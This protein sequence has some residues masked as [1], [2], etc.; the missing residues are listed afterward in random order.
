MQIKTSFARSAATTSPRDT[1]CAKGLEHA[2]DLIYWS[3]PYWPG[4]YLVGSLKDEKRK[5]A[6]FL[7]PTATTSRWYMR[8]CFITHFLFSRAFFFSTGCYLFRV[9]YC[10][11][12]SCENRDNAD[13]Q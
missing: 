3:A 13:T 10:H 12:G 2:C 8:G 7:F 9:A 6:S 4:A 5:E 1:L 11:S